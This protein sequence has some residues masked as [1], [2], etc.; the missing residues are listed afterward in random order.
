MAHLFFFGPLASCTRVADAEDLS[1]ELSVMG[2]SLLA[3]LMSYQLPRCFV[4]DG[5]GTR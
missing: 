3:L 4:D 2:M 5:R 1:F